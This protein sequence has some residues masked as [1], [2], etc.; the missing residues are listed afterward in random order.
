[1]RAKEFLLEL[2]NNPYP[3]PKRWA[4]AAYGAA[5]KSVTLPDGRELVISIESDNGIAVVNFLVGNQ[6]MIT[7]KG[8]A[9]K[10][11]ST[12]T[13]AIADYVRKYKPKYIAFT[14]S[15]DDDSRIK[16]YDRMVSGIEKSPQLS[17]YFDVTDQP[18]YWHEYLEATLDDFQDIRDQKLYVLMRAGR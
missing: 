17:N 13:I 14:S 4:G 12:V 15:I 5:E 8:D 18:D 7:G 1:M 6:Q 11:F 3:M 9:F 10:I 16:L 2:G